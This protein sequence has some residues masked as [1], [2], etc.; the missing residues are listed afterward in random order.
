MGQSVAGFVSGHAFSRAATGA[1]TARALASDV[2]GASFRVA[3]HSGL[4]A[5]IP[6]T[7][8]GPIACALAG[9][10]GLVPY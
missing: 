1:K 2:F 7:V 5:E 8:P 9:P 6:M 10:R 3:G 4:V